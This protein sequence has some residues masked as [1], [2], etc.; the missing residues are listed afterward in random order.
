MTTKKI[1]SIILFIVVSISWGCNSSSPEKKE[2]VQQKEQLKAPE[3]KASQS[4][5]VDKFGRK[6]G[7]P[8]Y[9]HNHSSSEPH[10]SPNQAKSNQATTSGEV[11][12]FGRK[13]GDPH[14][15]HNHE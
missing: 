4:G 3:K 12:K 7:D 11:D 6:K 14:Y 5:E 9:G 15:G 1:A 8:H 2:Q 10:K 13:P